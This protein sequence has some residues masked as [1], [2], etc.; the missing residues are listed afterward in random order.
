M[1]ESARRP[2]PPRS[3]PAVGRR[4]DFGISSGEVGAWLFPFPSSALD[5]RMSSQVAA[6]RALL[7]ERFPNAVPPSQGTARP[8]ST[9]IP[10]INRALPNGGFPR[11]R[12]SAWEPGGGAAA[13]LRSVCHTALSRTERV[14][15]VDGEGVFAAEPWLPDLILVKP[16]GRVETLK[17]A[18]EMAST[19]SIS[20][21]VVD[22]ARAE[23][24]ERQRLSAA[25]GEGG[26]AV[27]LLDRGA[28]LVGGVRGASS[29]TRDGIEW[30]RSE[31]GEP[32]E[33]RSVCVHARVSSLGWSRETT[34]TL[35]LWAPPARLCL[36]PN[37]LARKGKED[38]RR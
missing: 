7:A 35:P 17:C 32:I 15:W 3:L 12:L 30:S 29:F 8:L 9:G 31:I 20:L 24:G 2:P 28:T 26:A 37:W 16:P 10:E 22:G 23:R 19:G 1:P 5:A 18:E 25:A 33:I 27:I 14:V 36:D 21:V 11:G 13:I 6:L 34:F 38:P 4:L